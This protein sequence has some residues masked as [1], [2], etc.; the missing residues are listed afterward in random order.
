MHR[1]TT[2]A[3]AA[4]VTLITIAGCSGEGE[5]AP[6]VTPTAATSSAPG[7][8]GPT[9]SALPRTPTGFPFALEL[10]P[11][12]L[13]THG[14]DGASTTLSGTAPGAVAVVAARLRAAVAGAGYVESGYDNETRSVRLSFFTGDT[15][16]IAVV[17]VSPCDRDRSVFTLAPRE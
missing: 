2:A 1:R 15:V 4:I 16:G 6:V 7:C 11:G 14:A 5:G 12:A 3:A 17:S 13:V 10:P 8:A 9:G